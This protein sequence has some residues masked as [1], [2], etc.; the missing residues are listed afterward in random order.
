MVFET[1][2]G[3]KRGNKNVHFLLIMK[4]LPHVLLQNRIHFYL[5]KYKNVQSGHNSSVPMSFKWAFTIARRVGLAH[6]IR[7]GSVDPVQH[8]AVLQF[9]AVLPAA[10]WPPTCEQP[11]WLQ[12]SSQG[13]SAWGLPRGGRGS[14]LFP[15][16]HGCTRGRH[17]W[18]SPALVR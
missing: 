18:P 3:S 10:C 7:V 1:K 15:S 14:S 4:T 2:Q 8:G 17:R 5:C 6:A 12:S 11:G 16:E 13:C 9:I